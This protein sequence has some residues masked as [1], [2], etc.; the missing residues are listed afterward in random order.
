VLWWWME[1]RMLSCMAHQ[2]LQQTSYRAG[3]CYPASLPCTVPDPWEVQLIPTGLSFLQWLRQP[4]R[5]FKRADT[6]S[7]SRR[8]PL[9]ARKC[10][11]HFQPGIWPWQS[12]WGASTCPLTKCI[13][14]PVMKSAGTL[15]SLGWHLWRA[16]TTPNTVHGR[17]I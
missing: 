16:S 2:P 11:S 8:S 6:V 5:A 3:K 12:K 17:A 14:A 7:N 4:L 10:L 9:G 13:L 1:V 15:G